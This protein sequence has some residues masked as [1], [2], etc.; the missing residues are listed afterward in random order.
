MRPRSV[1]P[2]WLRV[3]PGTR[4]WVPED[5]EALRALER[6]LGELF[7]RWGYREVRTPIL[8]FLNTIERGVGAEGPHGLFVLVDR[9]GDLLAL[10]P[11]MTV[12]IARFVATLGLRRVRLFYIAEVF[13]SRDTARG[14][15]REFVQAGVERIGDGGPEADA[16]VVALAAWA[17]REAGL[18]RF[19]LGIGH[20]GFL[21]KLLGAAGLDA[22]EQ[23]AAQM[24]LYRRDFVGLGELLEDAP[25]EV[26]QA[27][28]GLPAWRGPDA[29]ERASRLRVA[30]EA[31]AEIE[32]LLVK[33]R[34]YGI[35]ADVEVDLGIIRDFEYYTG[36]VFE[37]YAHGVGRPL[38]GG[39]RYD[40]LLGRFGEDRPA[41][42]FA[43]ELDRLLPLVRAGRGEPA[44][45]IRYVASRH[46][47][48]ARL[49][50]ETRAAGVPTVL[51]AASEPDSP[52]ACIMVE[53]DRIRIRDRDG[54]EREV[55]PDRAVEEAVRMWTT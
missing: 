20:A 14:E 30:P 47:F 18:S 7:R 50:L 33:L 17:L 48:A 21:R 8:E 46:D 37:A 42:G 43:L 23:H 26:R 15:A 19:R 35:Q 45:P 11:E 24:L 6:R 5:V 27:I 28:L 51:E 31:L 53:D 16:E 12:P 3:P 54:R 40:G 52:G 38:L 41:I 4:D 44:L 10:R 32:A 25:G 39:G 9:T 2:L 49:A 13:R 36:V 29:L 55:A 34:P 1:P 22:Q